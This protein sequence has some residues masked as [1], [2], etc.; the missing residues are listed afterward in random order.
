MVFSQRICETSG[1]FQ[2]KYWAHFFAAACGWRAHDG[3][4]W[5]GEPVMVDDMCKLLVILIDKYVT[6][7]K[8]REWMGCWGLLGWWLIVMTGIIELKQSLL[9]IGYVALN[10][11]TGTAWRLS[12]MNQW[13]EW[14]SES[15][16]ILKP[17]NN[18]SAC[19]E[20]IFS[21]R[22]GNHE[23]VFRPISMTLVSKA[24][25]TRRA[26]NIRRPKSFGTWSI[27]RRCAACLLDLPWLT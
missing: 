5:S 21:K 9:W 15:F 19:D 2:S 8:R 7:A 3:W 12:V 13:S 25:G 16:R 22:P 23:L 1:F 10:W 14:C 27:S 17:T 24:A 18:V 6:G 26:G 11:L 20:R 4:D